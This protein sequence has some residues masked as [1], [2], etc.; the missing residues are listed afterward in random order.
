MN[1]V[2]IATDRMYVC[3]RLIGVKYIG[4]SSSFCPKNNFDFKKDKTIMIIHF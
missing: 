3:L 1:V 2:F 4:W